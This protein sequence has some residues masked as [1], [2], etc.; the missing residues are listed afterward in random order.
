MIPFYDDVGIFKRQ[1]AYKNCLAIYGV[2]CIDKN[3]LSES[4]N[5]S[6]TA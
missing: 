1:R 5:L 6:D 4:V 3:C 2:E